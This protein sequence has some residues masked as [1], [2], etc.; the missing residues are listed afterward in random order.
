MQS[1]LPKNPLSMTLLGL[2]ADTSGM[3]VVWYAEDVGR[4]FERINFKDAPRSDERLGRMPEQLQIA[5]FM[6]PNVNPWFCKRY[7][8][9]VRHC[10]MK[11]CW[12]YPCRRGGV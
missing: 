9:T 2:T 5:D 11:G 10:N 3:G 4:L 12:L 8:I 6:K 7:K 1:L